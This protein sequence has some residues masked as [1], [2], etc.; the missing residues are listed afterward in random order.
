MI[1]TAR[2]LVALEKLPILIAAELKQIK[3]ILRSDAC[4][5]FVHTKLATNTWT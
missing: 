2:G 4:K 5:L 1:R 3:P